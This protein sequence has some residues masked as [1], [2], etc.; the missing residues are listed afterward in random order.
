MGF[1]VGFFGLKGWKDVPVDPKTKLGHLF[2]KNWLVGGV[3]YFF[4]F[5]PT[6]GNDPIWLIFFKWVETTNQLGYH[7]SCFR[8]S[9]SKSPA[10]E[11]VFLTKWDENW[12]NQL[13]I[14]LVQLD[15]FE[16]SKKSFEGLTHASLVGLWPLN[17]GDLWQRV[18]RFRSLKIF[19]PT[20]W[21]HLPLKM[22][23]CFIANQPTSTY[24]TI[25]ERTLQDVEDNVEYIACS[26][27]LWVLHHITIKA[28][29]D[30]VHPKTL[31]LDLQVTSSIDGPA[32]YQWY[33]VQV[34][35]LREDTIGRRRWRP[36]RERR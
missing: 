6:W 31:V 9:A 4:I 22:G 1:L 33:E 3:K 15:N 13:P 8:K 34:C 27:A 35:V 16:A 23:S 18:S 20:T 30:R 5:T 2:D 19:T 29:H 21:P 17:A 32:P 24:R 28:V 36:W 14:Q 12:D 10:G 11:V 26:M 7:P 25:G